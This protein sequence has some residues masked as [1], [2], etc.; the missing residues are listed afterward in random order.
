MPQNGISSCQ[1]ST[2]YALRKIFRYPRH[3]T[4]FLNQISHSYHIQPQ[5]YAQRQTR[6]HGHYKQ[7]DEG[8]CHV[9]IWVRYYQ[10]LYIFRIAYHKASVTYYPYRAHINYQHIIWIIASVIRKTNDQTCVQY[11]C[12]MACQLYPVIRSSNGA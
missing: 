2:T 6:V 8:L 1:L 12:P 4:L 9:Y 11:C 3:K 10:M 5:N 7:P